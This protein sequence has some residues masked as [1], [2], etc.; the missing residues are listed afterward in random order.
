M[1]CSIQSSKPDDPVLFYNIRITLS[2][3]ERVAE[4]R[5][6]RVKRVSFGF[7]SVLSVIIGGC[8]V[9]IFLSL[10]FTILLLLIGGLFFRL[11]VF[12][13]GFASLSPVAGGVVKLE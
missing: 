5:W 13:G 1:L 12:L 4:E 2:S 3:E 7:H 9:A 6:D 11:Y 10:L 8:F